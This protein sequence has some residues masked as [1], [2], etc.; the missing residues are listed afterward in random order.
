MTVAP[1]ATGG[2]L[3]YRGAVPR[4]AGCAPSI[5]NPP[6]FS[7]L[8]RKT[9]LEPRKGPHSRG[10][11]GA[12]AWQSS[13]LH[14]DLR[15]T[16]SPLPWGRLPTPDTS[17]QRTHFPRWLREKVP[18]QSGVPTQGVPTPPA[19]AALS[20]SPR[21][22]QTGTVAAGHWDHLERLSLPAPPLHPPGSGC[23]S[24]ASCGG[25]SQEDPADG[26]CMWAGGPTPSQ[27]VTLRFVFR[28]RP[29]APADGSSPS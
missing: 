11:L 9:C 14:L 27:H 12:R 26:A 2:H 17:T 21:T 22:N 29:Q 23:L 3:G 28:V 24:H 13:D 25:C 7:L 20:T 19:V 4:A 10:G 15:V 16:S 6:P 1:P 18:F 8:G 5:A